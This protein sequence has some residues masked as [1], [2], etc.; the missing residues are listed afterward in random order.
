V[1][2]Q[3]KA[4][5]AC[6]A[7]DFWAA[8]SCD[9]SNLITIPS[10]HC[11]SFP[12]S[13]VPS[14]HVR[15]RPVSLNTTAACKPSSM[16]WFLPVALAAMI[17][18]TEFT[19][20]SGQSAWYTAHLSVARW[21]LT[22]TSTATVAMFAGG[23]DSNF[24]PY[25]IVDLYNLTTSTWSTARLSAARFFLAATSVGDV[26][27]FAGGATVAGGKCSFVAVYRDSSF[28]ISFVF[29]TWFNF[30]PASACHLYI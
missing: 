4:A 20:A 26:S 13:A 16:S 28:E 29:Y 10:M 15:A 27:I 23:S 21:H 8:S 30:C 7:S 18:I 1:R 14:A 12:S 19:A 5:R 6:D 25:D 2:G 9:I 17:L 3:C 11:L 22:A 24:S